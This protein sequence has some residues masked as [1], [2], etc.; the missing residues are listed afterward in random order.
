MRES[1]D[2]KKTEGVLYYTHFILVKDSEYTCT[3]MNGKLEVD[4]TAYGG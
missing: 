2:E 1:R 3:R 4:S